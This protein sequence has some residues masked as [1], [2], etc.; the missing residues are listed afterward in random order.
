M[1][2]IKQFDIKGSKMH[3]EK[4]IKLEQDVE[5]AFEMN[6]IHNK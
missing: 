6:N 3:Q 5:K 1:L 2:E 4:I